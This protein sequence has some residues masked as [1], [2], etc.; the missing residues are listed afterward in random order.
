MEAGFHGS[1]VSMKPALPLAPSTA[2][3]SAVAFRATGEEVGLP[4]RIKIFSWGTNEGRTTGATINVGDKTVDMLPKYHAALGLDTVLLD[5]EHQSYKPHPNYKPDPRA[6]PGHGKIEVVPGEG[7]FLSALTYTPDGQAHAANYADV[8]AVAHLD[9]DGNLLYVSSVALTQYGDVAGLPFADHVAALSAITGTPQTTTPDLP[10]TTM[11]TPDYKAI[12]AEILGVKPDPQGVILDE[13]LADAVI[14]H[15]SKTAATSA[16]PSDTP[17]GG[18]TVEALSARFDAA[19]RDRLVSDASRE[20]KVIPLSNEAIH[21]MDPGDL[22]ELISKLP[23]NV[24]PMSTTTIAKEQPAARAV[25]LSAEQAA[26]AKSLGL[27][28]EEYLKG[29]A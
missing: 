16:A 19:E 15:Q 8:S 7:V 5:Y 14:K 3:S 28:E 25:A 27:T 22:K 18:V 2:L 9:D 29:K 12:L 4:S 24:V 6:V 21:R 26:A 10:Q 1:I 13:T 17:A 11:T 20:G 23:S